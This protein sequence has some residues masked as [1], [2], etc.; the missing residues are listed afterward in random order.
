MVDREFTYLSDRLP[1]N[2]LRMVTEER[3]KKRNNDDSFHSI[4]LLL[5]S[6]LIYPRK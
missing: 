1:P 6:I 3:T 5:L 2:F 4:L